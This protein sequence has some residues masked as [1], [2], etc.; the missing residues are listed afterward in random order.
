MKNLKIFAPDI[1]CNVTKSGIAARVVSQLMDRI[2]YNEDCS[3]DVITLHFDNS[4]RCTEIYFKNDKFIINGKAYC[5]PDAIHYV[6]ELICS[7]LTI[8]P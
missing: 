5:L 3:K 8:A 1:D 4:E 6:T 2:Y 7:N